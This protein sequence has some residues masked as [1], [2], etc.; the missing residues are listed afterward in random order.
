MVFL[1]KL[2]V[3]APGL[4][5][6]LRNTYMRMIISPN[7][8]YKYGIH[9]IPN[10][11]NKP[12]T[13][14]NIYKYKNTIHNPFMQSDSRSDSNSTTHINKSK[15][16]D[17]MI[18]ANKETNTNDSNILSINDK[19]TKEETNGNTNGNTN[20]STILSINNDEVTLVEQRLVIDGYS[21]ISHPLHTNIEPVKYYYQATD[22]EKKLFSM[23]Y[24]VIKKRMFITYGA[25]YRVDKL[26]G[27]L[28]HF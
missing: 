23:P 6:A 1:T 5:L 26:H 7:T 8:C 12:I 20:T 27:K 3:V 24:D 19:E 16:F 18:L 28:L 15:L 17:I 11:D 10:Y 14:Y 25:P 22:A 4:G 9:Q 21:Y 13:I 2:L